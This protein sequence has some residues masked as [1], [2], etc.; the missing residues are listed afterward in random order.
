MKARCFSLSL[1]LLICWLP[2]VLAAQEAPEPAAE[3]AA[4]EVKVIPPEHASARATMRTFL[5]AFDPSLSS[6]DEDP[7]AV[8]AACLDLSRISESLR[9]RQGRELAV[10]L[11]EV[12]DKTELIDVGT[13]SDD[14]Q[15]KPYRLR[16]FDYGQ[17][18]IDRDTGGEW[19]FT[20][21]TVRAIPELLAALR[22][23]E[24][25]EG[26]T[27]IE[28]LTPAM[29]L[30]SKMPR[31]LQQMGF[32]MEH[33]Q[34]LGLLCLLVVALILERI[35]AML[36]RNVVARRLEESLQNVGEARLK[37]AMRPVGLLVAALVCWA[38]IYWFGFPTG[39][40]EVLQVAVHF[41][42][43]TSFV[44]A[45]YRFVDVLAATLEARAASTGN[46]FDDLLVP[47]VRKT[48]K[49][50]ITAFGLVF[51]ADTLRLPVRSVLTGIGIGGLAIALAA[52]DMVKNLFG[53]LL[54]IMDRP[55]SV[56]DYVSVGSVDGTVEELGFRSTRI[57]TPQNSLVTLPNSHLITT[58]V[59]NLGARHY[60]RWRTTLSLTYDTPPAKIE[61]F[62]EGVKALILEHPHTRKEGFQVV[63]NEF[64][65]SSL[66]VMLHVFFDVP[67]WAT[68]LE[69][70]Q[71]LGLDVLR[72]AESLGV[73]MAFPTQTVHLRGETA[74]SE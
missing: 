42:V 49:I 7:L 47:L 19:L 14:P 22:E 16:V 2:T 65:A 6:P 12:L 59:D 8:A 4:S 60:R 9:V 44:W 5:E 40:L 29:W 31:S 50:L 62:C 13:I 21:E 58:A 20:S 28:P 63:F 41:S 71:R 11:K 38:A 64:S 36:C 73:E 27:A 39:V 35:V 10:Q 54:V 53:S 52:Q 46:K 3:E 43:A 24:T 48:F 34:W 69:S 51:I 30:R 72:L 26:V 45:S 74:G 23:R 61:A 67:D 55:F 33:W 17:V 15:G 57:R 1:L 56:G 18:R 32:L 66:D 25:V 68:E 70:R 37:R